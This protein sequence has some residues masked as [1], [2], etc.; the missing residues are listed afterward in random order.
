[1]EETVAIRPITYSLQ[2]R[3]CVREVSERVLE[4][5]ATAPSQCLVTN[6]GGDGIAGRFESADG[7]EALLVT[8]LLVAADGTFD[9][10]GTISVGRNTSVRFRT[11]GSGRLSASPDPQLRHGAAVCGIEEGRGQFEH[12]WGRITSNLVLSDTAELTDNQLGV[13]FVRQRAGARE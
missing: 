12:A 2:F 11:I 4:L 9:E 5:R 10:S 6:V 1:M 13:I 7:Q 3:G 8:R